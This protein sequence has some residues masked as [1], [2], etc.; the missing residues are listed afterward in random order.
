[1]SCILSKNNKV[2]RISIDPEEEKFTKTNNS[3]TFCVE[4]ATG[5]SF[6][7]NTFDF[8]YSV[9]VI[10]HMYEKY[11]LA[12]K[13]IIRVTKP[14]KYM[15]LAFPVSKLHTEEWSDGS[16][17]PG[18]PTNGD[19]HFFQYR[20]SSVDIDKI[21]NQILEAGATIKHEDIFWER[22]DGT[23]DTMLMRLKNKG[24]YPVFILKSIILNAYYG[25]TLFRLK[26]TSSFEESKLF[27]NI[28]FIIKK[29]D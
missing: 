18:Q 6:A 15:Y 29:N 11:M 27:G 1:M 16:G 10:E 5:L 13:E 12:I 7:D 9:S 2:T 23:Y 8:S 14:G 22:K 17:Y 21:K 3:L 28:H 25:L 26:P 4:D 19:K 20:F 24:A